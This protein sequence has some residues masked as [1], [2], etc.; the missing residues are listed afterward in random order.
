MYRRA[1]LSARCASQSIVRGREQ[2]WRELK[3]SSR[4][5]LQFVALK[6]FCPESIILLPERH[7][8]RSGTE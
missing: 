5:R 4:T 3:L 7:K 8:D 2:K 1:K 6:D